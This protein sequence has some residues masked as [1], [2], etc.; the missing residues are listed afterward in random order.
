MQATPD[1][2]A[3]PPEV[4]PVEAPA[5][6]AVPAT[7]AEPPPPPVQASAAPAPAP[8]VPPAPPQAPPA[9]PGVDTLRSSAGLDTIR[10]EPPSHPFAREEDR[11]LD[12]ISLLP[13]ALTVLLLL[14][15]IYNCVSGDESEDGDESPPAKVVEQEPAE[16]EES[17][18][19]RKKGGRL[20]RAEAVP[21]QEAEAPPPA[22]EPKDGADPSKP[23]KVPSR[24]AHIGE[25]EGPA[26]GSGG[27]SAHPEAERLAE[28]AEAHYTA[29]RHDDAMR[30]IDGAMRAS[31][32]VA[33]FEAFRA[34]VLHKQHRDDEALK[35][36]TEAVQHDS[37]NPEIYRQR[38]TVNVA[39]GR[40]AHA[41]RD[42][43]AY[44]RLKAGTSP[45]APP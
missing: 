12:P 20:K 32:K 29:G 2:L 9:D 1:V 19:V 42:M 35:Q 5:A 15:T 25:Y 18:P 28:E 4:S 16:S 30:A 21:T 36:Y 38:A 24:L 44:D 3:P 27:P 6:P 43:R 34:L 22:A 31:P 37:K 41:S 26:L 39:L 45:S 40:H 7:P 14:G 33:R 13:V 8:S 23:A 10:N 17:T 11:G